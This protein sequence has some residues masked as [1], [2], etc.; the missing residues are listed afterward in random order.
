MA[1]RLMARVNQHFGVELTLRVLFNAP[2]VAGLALA[3]TQAQ[4][5]AEPDFDQVLA[6]VEQMQGRHLKSRPWSDERQGE[7]Y[8]QPGAR[9]APTSGTHA[10]GACWWRAQC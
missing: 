7:A 10:P 9:A 1:A 8:C 5:E 2:T 3:V 6:Q 4:A